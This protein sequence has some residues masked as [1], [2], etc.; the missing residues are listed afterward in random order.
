MR[1]YS[2]YRV[3][4][5]LLDSIF[6]F[7]FIIIIIIIIIILN[8]RT[9]WKCCTQQVALSFTNLSSPCSLQN[10]PSMEAATHHN[11]TIF[12]ERGPTKL[13]HRKERATTTSCRLDEALAFYSW[14]SFFGSTRR[15]LE[16]VQPHAIASPFSRV[17]DHLYKLILSLT[18]PRK[19]ASDTVHVCLPSGVHQN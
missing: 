9:T 19:C 2:V 6:I 1:V 17:S 15:D 4:N 10:T 11:C 5:Y 3:S 14:S 16:R 13:W 12:Q 18:R 8:T 7:I